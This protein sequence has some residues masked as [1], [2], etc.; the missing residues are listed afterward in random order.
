M[1]TYLSFRYKVS[2]KRMCFKSFKNLF[3]EVIVL[4]SFVGFLANDEGHVK[5]SHGS[6]VNPGMFPQVILFRKI[7][8]MLYERDLSFSTIIPIVGFL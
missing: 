8:S 2:P 3:E 7:R 5:S 6:F 4:V 1:P